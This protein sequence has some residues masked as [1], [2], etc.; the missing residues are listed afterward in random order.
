MT[1]T[2]PTTDKQIIIYDAD[3]AQRFP[4]Q[5]RRGNSLFNV[6]HIFGGVRDELVVE[7]DRAR[8]LRLTEADD[9][10]TDDGDA[11]AISSSSAV[12]IALDYWTKSDARGEGYAGKV[13]PKD[14]SYSVHNLLLS[15]EVVAPK[16]VLADDLCPEED[17][18][19][20]YELRCLFDGREC[21]TSHTIYDEP[22]DFETYQ[23][24][25]SR[26]LLVRG[27]RF[28]ETDQRIPSRMKRLAALYDTIHRAHSG[29]AGRIPVHHKMAVVQ[30]HFR[31]LQKSHAGNSNALPSRSPSESQGSGT[32]A[33]A[34]GAPASDAAETSQQQQA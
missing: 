26:Q 13:A 22:E 27:T 33:A 14:I 5:T 20:T 2:T 25:M 15:A 29:Y 10:E 9:T 34:S 23:A 1:P 21:V 31:Q 17:E 11:R 30:F 6:A 7:M 16:T 12:A 32:A 8:D 18:P 24:I 19:L 28:G 3:A 4:F